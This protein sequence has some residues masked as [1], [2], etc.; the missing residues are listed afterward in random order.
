MWILHYG[1]SSKCLDDPPK[2]Y[3]GRTR[4]EILETA[5]QCDRNGIYLGGIA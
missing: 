3:G 1:I 2:L 4:C 5:D